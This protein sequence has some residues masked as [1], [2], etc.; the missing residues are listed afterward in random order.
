MRKWKTRRVGTKR[1]YT[2]SG[3]ALA[4]CIGIAAVGCA[5]SSSGGGSGGDSTINIGA[6]IPETGSFSAYAPLLKEGMDLALQQIH[7][8][9]GGHKVNLI[10]LD[11]ATSLTTALSDARQLV[12]SDHVV[13]ILGPLNS[14]ITSGLE[15]FLA[16]SKVPAIAWEST[17]S[18]AGQSGWVVTPGGDLPQISYSTGLYAASVLKLKTADMVTDD[19]VAG[20][21]IGGGFAMGFKDGGGKIVQPQ[22]DPLGTTSFQPYVSALANARAVG[23]WN[24]AT[25]A[26]FIQDYELVQGAKSKQL[27]IDYADVPF[28]SQITNALGRS[29]AGTYSDTS[30][31]YALD[32]PA[33]KKFVAAFKSAYHAD[34]DLNSETAYEDTLLLIKALQSTHETTD[35][36]TLQKALH[37][38]TFSGPAGTVRMGPS[39]FSTRTFY[40]V[41]LGL[42]DGAYTWIP[43]HE[44]PKVAPILNP[45]P[46]SQI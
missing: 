27:I 31:T 1:K 26:T 45:I 29:F 9:I 19:Y 13:A 21:E 24:P 15:P 37:D 38:A 46:K 40:I 17:P 36:V 11:D 34:P 32:T 22:W 16:Q 3:A 35:S 42:Y 25:E 30:Y 39:G 44:Y 5:S 6:L 23:V 20:W 12:D 8:T 43:V 10:A 33:N 41:K 2:L 7:Y 18:S 4:V 28:Q 14:E